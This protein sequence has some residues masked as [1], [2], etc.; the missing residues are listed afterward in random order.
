MEMIMISP[1]QL[2]VMMD[3]ND[4]MEYDLDGAAAHCTPFARREALRR[5]LEK[6]RENTGFDSEGARV[7]VRMF[8]SRDGGCEMFVALLG[9][10]F[11][12]A[13]VPRGAVKV[14]ARD[15]MT[16]YAFSSL[17]DLL[18]A[19]RRLSEARC[20]GESYAYR[21]R[22]AKKWYLALEQSSP[23]VCEMGGV[24]IRRGAIAYINEYC[25]LICADAVDTL[26]A[27][28]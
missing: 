6:A 16:V 22:E 21:E 25:S 4:M 13:D 14:T 26:A 2:K 24:M 28:A 3:A 9:G 17:H 7:T 12:C 27:L 18:C 19:C 23:L 10:R 8:P 15:G 1:S 5:I 11:A 20:R